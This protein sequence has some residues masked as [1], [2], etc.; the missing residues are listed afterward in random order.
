MC[1]H[2]CQCIVDAFLTA[3]T[4]FGLLADHCNLTSVAVN[5]SRM[6]ATIHHTNTH[7]LS[8][9]HL[10]WHVCN[11][12][13]TYKKRKKKTRSTVP[14]GVP[15]SKA[16]PQC[17]RRFIR[18]SKTTVCGGYRYTWVSISVCVCVIFLMAQ[19]HKSENRM[20]TCLRVG[21]IS[22]SMFC[23]CCCQSNCK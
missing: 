16:Q 17:T 18:G 4:A 12:L 3:R 7:K 2:V 21:R 23:C 1:L 10:Q 14:L 5:Q 13:H 11:S 22:V 20:A 15:N 6:H 8:G 19:S 9:L